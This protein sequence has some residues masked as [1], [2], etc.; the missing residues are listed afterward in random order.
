MPPKKSKKRKSSSSSAATKETPARKKPSKAIVTPVFE[1]VS[2][3]GSSKCTPKQIV[4]AL[5]HI[6]L[7][8]PRYHDL[9]FT[10]EDYVSILKQ[11]YQGLDSLT[12]TSFA[13]AINSDTIRP[14][15]GQDNMKNYSGGNEFGVYANEIEASFKQGYERKTRLSWEAASPKLAHA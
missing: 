11:N 2:T 3:G 14:F 7:A 5:R 1:A 13:R 15:G 10:S 4:A 8:L 9:W 6:L 12:A